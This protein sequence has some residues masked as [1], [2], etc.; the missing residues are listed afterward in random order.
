MKTTPPAQISPLPSTS[1]SAT[2]PTTAGNA[3]D[4]AAKVGEQETQI[5]KLLSQGYRTKVVNGTTIYCRS[6]TVLGSRFGSQL[7]GTADDLE[8]SNRSSK[9]AA[10]DVQ[11]KALMGS[12]GGK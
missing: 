11:R 9:D 10:G 2:A 6:E 8:K 3:T 5:K 7:C 4:D 1:P 12:P